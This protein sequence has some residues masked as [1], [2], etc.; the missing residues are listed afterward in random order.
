VQNS[1]LPCWLS[2]AH[3]PKW[4]VEKINRLVIRI[5]HEKSLSL[6]TFFSLSEKQ[7]LADFD[8]GAED[9]VDL[10]R[11]R[12]ELPNS[13]FLAEDLLAQGFTVIPIN[14]LLYSETL[15]GNLKTK[16]APPV[17][18]L[19]G[20]TDLLKKHSVAVVGSRNASD[21]SL[22]F[23]D[24]IARKAVDTGKVI[25][26]GYAKGVD[27]QALDSAL[28]YKGTSIIV[29]PQ[30]IMT[31]ASGFNTYYRQI[32]SGN[33]LVL[34]SFHPKAH[35]SV[36][37]AMARNSIIYGLAREIYVAQ[38]GNKGGTWAGVIDGLRKGRMIYVRAPVPGE[39]TA[40]Q[41]LINKG[42]V[43]VD[44]EGSPVFA[45]ETAPQKEHVAE[46]R[47]TYM[48]DNLDAKIIDALQGRSLTAKQI[49]GLIGSDWTVQKMSK[50][51]K[52]MESLETVEKS[53]PLKFKMRSESKKQLTLFG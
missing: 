1:E 22:R 7:W 15:K 6:D 16:Y 11:A 43:G 38:S 33:V 48:V 42:A 30:G 18:Y 31:F 9:I 27:R 20:N 35:W 21:L 13:S 2:L 53:K 39:D 25:V 12:K 5:I 41:L 19:K 47:A 52:A 29:L 45:T 24:T 14:S 34:S 51:L 26:S 23:T 44:C 8:L 10:Q 37:L 28:T 17:L 40:N 46:E 4:S 49:V 32:V 50:H 36:G 3:L